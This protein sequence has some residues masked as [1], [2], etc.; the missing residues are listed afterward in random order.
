M[1]NLLVVN[2]NVLSH[3]G[4]SADSQCAIFL[5]DGKLKSVSLVLPL[6]SCRPYSDIPGSIDK[7]GEILVSLNERLWHFGPVMP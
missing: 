4:I 6:L 3:H 5:A 2:K 1:Y 7:I